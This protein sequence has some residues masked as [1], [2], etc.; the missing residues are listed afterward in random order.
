MTLK[1]PEKAGHR[2]LWH[3]LH[4]R[5]VGCETQGRPGRSGTAYLRYERRGNRHRRGTRGGAAAALERRALRTVPKA[6][7]R[8]AL[9]EASAV[10]P[11]AVR[12]QV[13]GAV[14]SPVTGEA[15][16]GDAGSAPARDAEAERDAASAARS[17]GARTGRLMPGTASGTAARRWPLLAS[18]ARSDRSD[19]EAIGIPARRVETAQ[20]DWQRKPGREGTRPNPTHR[21]SASQSVSS[22]EHHRHRA[23]AS[24]S[25]SAS[26]SSSPAN[27]AS[28]CRRPSAASSGTDDSCDLTKASVR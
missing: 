7:A 16:T 20:R 11:A 2:A 24:A 13:R 8:S 19:A 4:L 26:A 17:A 27:T 21:T 23:P 18:E 28:C 15:R 12:T 25:E 10:A 3:A 5:C 1:D 9:P 6:V 22:T 14:R